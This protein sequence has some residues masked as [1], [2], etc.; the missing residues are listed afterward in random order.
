M[1][2]KSG[3]RRIYWAGTLAA[4]FVLR[5]AIM[6][7]VLHQKPGGWP[8]NSV[9]ELGT[10]ARSIVEGRG[11]SSPFGGL[12]GP[13][14][15]LAP[16]YPALVA[17]IFSIFGVFTPASAAV[18]MLMQTLFSLATIFLIMKVAKEEFGAAAANGCGIFW[19]IGPQFLWLPAVFWDVSVTIL[20]VIASIALALSCSRRPTRANWALMGLVGGC[21][22]LVN[23]S[24][25]LMLAAVFCWTVA[26]TWRAS[27]AGPVLSVLVLLAVFA[28]WP[29]RN[30]RVMHAFIPLRSNF[31][32]EFW[33]GNRPEATALDSTAVYPVF[34]REEYDSYVA[35]GEV[36][37]MQYKSA[38]AKEYIATHPGRFARLSGERFLL[39]WTGGRTVIGGFILVTTILGIGGLAL[40]ARDG[41]VSLAVLLCLPLIVFPLPYYF[42]HAEPRFRLVM[43]P[44]TTL[45]SAYAVQRLWAMVKQ[46]RVVSGAR[47]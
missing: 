14:A 9:G 38:L 44:I 7:A 34:D 32:F 18:V 46:R 4:A 26:R 8:L 31:G 2:S 3:P 45:L 19:T 29:V 15:F 22:L 42:T 25:A 16:G 27:Y 36:A 6:V 47:P 41:R 20:F 40:L 12:T 30:Q 17:V 35:K 1:S 11:I 28:W 23:P 5:L 39:Y 37:Y 43:E 13:T 24:L 33:K 10:I 21:A